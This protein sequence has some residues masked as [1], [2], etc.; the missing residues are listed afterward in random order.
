MGDQSLTAGTNFHT[1]TSL[2]PTLTNVC[3]GLSTAIVDNNSERAAPCGKK[4]C[5]H[6]NFYFAVAE[7][8]LRG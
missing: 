3:T 8:A 7:N 5:A 1:G 6:A 4:K 2:T